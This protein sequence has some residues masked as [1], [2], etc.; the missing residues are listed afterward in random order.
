MGLCASVALSLRAGIPASSRL[1]SPLRAGRA[2]WK[3]PLRPGNFQFYRAI[4]AF[5]VLAVDDQRS[6]SLVGNSSDG[7]ALD[8]MEDA[9]AVEAGAFTV[10]SGAC[11]ACA[12]SDVGLG[13]KFLGAAFWSGFQFDLY[14]IRFLRVDVF[15]FCANGSA[16]AAVF[17]KICRGKPS[18]YWIG[19]HADQHW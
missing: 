1:A 19:S 10:S 15:S 8:Y 13:V 5:L 6:R 3:I 4:F 18:H 12:I 16:E 14:G 17:E 2:P 7:C 11:V 9:V